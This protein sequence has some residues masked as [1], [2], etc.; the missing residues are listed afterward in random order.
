[1]SAIKHY[2]LEEGPSIIDLPGFFP[3]ER[4]LTG[5]III[6]AIVGKFYLE[7][8]TEGCNKTVSFKLNSKFSPEG[9]CAAGT[10][11]DFDFIPLE[12]PY[13]RLSLTKYPEGIAF[14]DAVVSISTYFY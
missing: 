3:L 10:R 5:C 14:T 1:M 8:Y 4:K 2:I 13:L 7:G 9:D 11:I 12:H 6:Q